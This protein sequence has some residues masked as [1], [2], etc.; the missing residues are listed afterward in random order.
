MSNL[1]SEETA[2]LHFRLKRNLKDKQDSFLFTIKPLFFKDSAV[3]HLTSNDSVLSV[4]RM[5]IILF[6]KLCNPTC[7]SK[8]YMTTLLCPPC[9]PCLCFRSPCRTIYTCVYVLL[10][11][12]GLF[13]PPNPP[14]GKSLL[15]GYKSLVFLTSK[16][17]LSKLALG[18]G[19]PCT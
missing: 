5:A 2:C 3:P 7:V 15:L 1:K 11:S 9:K 10:L 6:Q 14:F 18:R 4:P 19:S 12:P 13:C 8:C 16:A 17:Y